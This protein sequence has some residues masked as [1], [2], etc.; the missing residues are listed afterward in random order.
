MPL[1][2][3]DSFALLLTSIALHQMDSPASFIST[4]L[5]PS[6][7]VDSKHGDKLNYESTISDL[8]GVK[9][10]SKEDGFG[11]VLGHKFIESKDKVQNVPQS[12]P[13]IQIQNYK[14]AKE[15]V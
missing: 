10:S 14:M 5:P 2:N 8:A 12:H 11:A 9:I 13:Y 15:V 3:I 6:S 7:K 4:G 1:V